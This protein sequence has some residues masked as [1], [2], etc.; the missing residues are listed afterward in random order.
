MAT[1]KKKSNNLDDIIPAHWMNSFDASQDGGT[2]LSP[3]QR[4]KIVEKAYKD[5]LGR[6]PDT[7]DLNYYKYSSAGE[8]EIRQE[9]LEGKEHKTLIENGREFKKLKNLLAN[10]ESKI[11]A[12]ESEIRD[13][14]SSF[15]QMNSLLKE[16]NLHIEELRKREKHP[17]EST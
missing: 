7:R 9:L 8:E 6:D 17:F 13:Q 10:A 3:S 15:E 2:K 16:K 14:K 1:N 11:K 12:L 4:V 5:I